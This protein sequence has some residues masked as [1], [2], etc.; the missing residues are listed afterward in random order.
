M[1]NLVCHGLGDLTQQSFFF[2]VFCRPPTAWQGKCCLIWCGLILGSC[3]PK[4]ELSDVGDRVLKVRTV[5]ILFCFL[6]IARGWAGYML[7]DFV[8]LGLGDLT[9]QPLFFIFVVW[10]VAHSWAGEM[11]FNLVWFVVGGLF[12]Q[13]FLFSI[14][15]LRIA[16]GWAG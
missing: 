4:S 8:R 1:L 7:L 6:P 2:H 11:L 15:V 10:P 5:R 13:S 16:H 14:F 3:F 12:Q 9:Q